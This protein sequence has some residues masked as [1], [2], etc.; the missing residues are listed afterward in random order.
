MHVAVYVVIVALTLLGLSL[1]FAGCGLL[2]RRAFG[3]RVVTADDCLLAPWT[4]FALVLFA[5]QLWHLFWPVDRLALLLV[6]GAG[7]TGWGW[8]L[9]ALKNVMAGRRRFVWALFV[10]LAASLWIASHTT[11]QVRV[12]DS[13]LYHLAS[14]R[15]AYTYPI[16]PG[17]GNLHGRLAFNN[18]YFLY[19]A[20]FH[21]GPFVNRAHHLANGLLLCWMM[22][23]I[24]YSI[25][26]LF[27]LPE[28][29]SPR[30]VFD[31]MMLVPVIVL[32]MGEQS[33]S[34]T[35]DAA[36][37]LLG[38]AVASELLQWMARPT[39]SNGAVGSDLGM[40]CF[41]VVSI[42]FLSAC[43]MT[44]KSSFLAFGFV[45]SL[46]ALTGCVTPNRRLNRPAA[47]AVVWSLVLC[48]S[49]LASW[50]FRGVILS[51]YPLYPA[52]CLGFPVSWRVPLESV[53][54]EN[55]WIRSWAR[56]P[57][58]VPN[59]VLGNWRWLWPWLN[60][61][62]RYSY[63]VVVPLILTVG[64]APLILMLHRRRNAACR[65]STWLFLLAPLASLVFWFVMAPEH[66]FAGSNFWVLGAGAVALALAKADGVT[67]LSVVL[68]LQAVLFA[69]NVDGFE[70]LRQWRKDIG[71]ARKGHVVQRQTDSGLLVYVPRPGELCW[72]A[73]LPSARKF[74]PGLRLRVTGDLSKGFLPP[75][76]VDAK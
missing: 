37:Y 7:I 19:A 62:L 54:L 17:L 75:L 24:L 5:L 29:R 30:L 16:V 6:V 42:T 61:I 68:S 10:T 72:D 25:Y 53:R 67:K 52:A 56:S 64:V 23:R 2:L 57:G 1:A 33:S 22:F 46:L 34:P 70:F 74:E 38:M 49:L 63:A 28:H 43:G 8:N 71:P 26:R 11:T 41:P 55:A 65:G 31:M 51:G 39:A 9:V 36:I 21:V 12:T 4:G 3:L 69:N 15:W 59:E 47:K 14:V 32:A 73:P 48:C 44:V 60:G 40:D 27:L 13:G 76:P 18:S 58:I 50:M 45:V 20:L 35:P 66:R